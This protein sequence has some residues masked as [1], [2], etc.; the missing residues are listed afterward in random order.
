MASLSSR[1]IEEF[2]K[3]CFD[4][5]Q[6]EYTYQGQSGKGK[7]DGEGV[8]GGIKVQ[9]VLSHVISD[10]ALSTGMYSRLVVNGKQII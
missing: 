9:H 5:A 4:G 7:I 1:E 6:V 2:K 8:A 3:L 10:Y